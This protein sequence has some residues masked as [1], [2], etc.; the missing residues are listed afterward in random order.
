MRG[1]KSESA[2]YCFRE[3]ERMKEDNVRG[4]GRNNM[5]TGREEGNLKCSNILEV[6]TVKPLHKSASPEKLKMYIPFDTNI[7]LLTP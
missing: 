3:E 4:G 5:Y 7:L 2:W 6:K 1:Q